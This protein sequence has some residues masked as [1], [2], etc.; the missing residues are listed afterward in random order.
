MLPRLRS[1][2]LQLPTPRDAR[3]ILNVGC[4]AYPCARTLHGARPGWVRWGVDWD[5]DALRRARQADPGLRLV[6]A[7]ARHGP[8]VLRTTFGLVVVRHP[9]L[10]RHRAA[11]ERI[12]ATLPDLLAPGGALLITLYAPEE[13]ALVQDVERLPVWPVD[14]GRLAPVDLAGHD[15]FVVAYWQECH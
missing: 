14:E 10:F 11:W 2:L 13:V 9:D 4:G 5:G 8:G 7:D 6:Q 12:M 3:R 1:V 15:R